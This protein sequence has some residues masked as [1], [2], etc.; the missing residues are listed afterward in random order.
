MGAD[1]PGLRIHGVPSFRP[2]E[3]AILFLEPRAGVHRLLHLMQGAFLELDLG[4]RS[5]V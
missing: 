4:D 5:L 1:G 2:G 3:R